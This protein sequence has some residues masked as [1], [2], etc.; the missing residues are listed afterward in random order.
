MSP[1]IIEIANEPTRQDQKEG[2]LGWYAM[3]EY[4]RSRFSYTPVQAEAV[5]KWIKETR[6]WNSGAGD[7]GAGIDGAF[8]SALAGSHT[9]PNYVS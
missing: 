5:E 6:L 4:G 1:S 8:W 9:S 3:P 2:L 7:S